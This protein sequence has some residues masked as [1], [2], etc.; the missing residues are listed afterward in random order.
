MQVQAT[1]YMSKQHETKRCIQ[2]LIPTLTNIGCHIN[3]ESSDG[4]FEGVLKQLSD[5]QVIVL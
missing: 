4:L 5:Q 3:A 2:L 1:E